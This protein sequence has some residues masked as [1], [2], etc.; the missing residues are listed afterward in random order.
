M[1][2]LSTIILVLFS[3]TALSCGPSPDSG[4][5]AVEGTVVSSDG[6]P[7]HYRAAGSGEPALVFVHAWSCDGGYWEEQLEHFAPGHRV[8]ALDLGGHGQS[9]TGR[10]SWSMAAFASDVQT[11]VETL[12]LKDVVLIGHS[13]GGAVVV[14]AALRMP[15]RV[16]AV[17]GVD[18][19]QA[20]SMPLSPDQIAG[21]VGYL[22]S[23]FRTNVDAWVRTMFPADADSV[24]VTRVAADM[25]SAPPEVGLGA[26]RETLDWYSHAAPG[27]LERL[28]VPLKCINSDKNPTDKDGLSARVKGY[29]LRLMPGRGHFLMLEDPETFDRLLEETVAEFP[30]A[31]ASR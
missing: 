19:F 17:V 12:D 24:L 9:G 16:R 18:N 23:D 21:F 26:L 14:E 27:A 11:V 5:A 1:R 4:S 7:I 3:L 6:L 30:D 10:E 2:C 31:R 8:I 20:V 15:G 13:M 22:Q 28:R 25:A 29:S